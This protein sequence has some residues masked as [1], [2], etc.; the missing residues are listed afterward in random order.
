MKL[1]L[2]ALVLLL[3]LV[4]P[5]GL[6]QAQDAPRPQVTEVPVVPPPIDEPPICLDFVRRPSGT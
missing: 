3:A 4:V 5:L 6:A 1:R 2:L